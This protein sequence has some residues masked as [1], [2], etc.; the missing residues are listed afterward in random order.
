[1]ISPQVNHHLSSMGSFSISFFQVEENDHKLGVQHVGL[2]LR[3]W[4]LQLLSLLKVFSWPGPASSN[5]TFHLSPLANFDDHLVLSSIIVFSRISSLSL[6][7]QSVS[8]LGTL[9]RYTLLSLC[10]L[11]WFSYL[12][13]Y[14]IDSSSSAMKS[15]NQP[16]L[17]TIASEHTG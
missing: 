7:P 14:L 3:P 6:Q 1:M 9:T 10:G 8:P 15:G 4:P 17:L 5:L 13:I 2:E 12:C 11:C 16:A